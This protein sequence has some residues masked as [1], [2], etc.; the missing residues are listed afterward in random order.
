MSDESRVSVVIDRGPDGSLHTERLRLDV[1]V[2]DDL[3][4]VHEV[5]ADPLVWQHFPSLRHTE[6]ST[7]ERMLRAWIGGWRRDGLGP[8]IVRAHDDERALGHGGCRI[9]KEGF[10]NLGYRFAPAA[11]GNGYATELAGAAVEIAQ[12]VRPELP[13]VAYLLEHNL[14]SKRVAEK[15]GLRFQFR[16]PDA[17]NPDH[18]AIRLVYADRDLAPEQLAAT[19]S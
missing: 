6:R 14:A 2:L 19:M 16:G 17:G 8:W 5:C 4:P 18:T 3:D 1:P 13:V 11:Q 7:T 9:R 12:Q 10:W 15:I